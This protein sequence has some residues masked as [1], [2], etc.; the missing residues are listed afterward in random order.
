MKLSK[1]STYLKFSKNTTTKF[2]NFDIE[3]FMLHSK[4]DFYLQKIFDTPS[5]RDLIISF[6]SFLE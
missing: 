6:L 3:V 2:T 5:P 4:V 1:K